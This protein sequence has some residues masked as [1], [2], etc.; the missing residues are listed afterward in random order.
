MNIAY[1]F[2]PAPNILAA[3]KVEVL[4]KNVNNTASLTSGFFVTKGVYC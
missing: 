2:S 4:S 3:L 1:F